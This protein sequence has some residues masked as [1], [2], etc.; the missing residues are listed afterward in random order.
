MNSN[1][2]RLIPAVVSFVTER[3]SY[4]TK[5]KLLKLL[6]LFDIEWYRV[7]QETYTGFGWMFHLLGPW[8]PEYDPALTILFA[9][10]NIQGRRGGDSFDTEFITTQEEVYLN[11]IFDDAKDGLIFEKVLST[12]GNKA[13]PEILDHVYFRTE[14]M[15]NG[16]RGEKLDFSTVSDRPPMLYS[17]V[18]SGRSKDEI[19]SL[20]RKIA[21]GIEASKKPTQGVTFTP[22]TYDNEFFEAMDKLESLK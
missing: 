11:R 7:H 13:T 18:R 2:T 5:T 14:P 16:T 4:V 12:W 21:E 20:R 15:R 10:E 1:L 6:Y 3:G 22:P 17:R 9:N 8:T 19:E